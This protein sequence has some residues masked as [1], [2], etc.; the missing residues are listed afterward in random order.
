ML[1]FRVVVRL[2]VIESLCARV[3]NQVRSGLAMLGIAVAVAIV[4]LRTE[5]AGQSLGSAW[6]SAVISA[7][8]PP[9]LRR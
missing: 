8:W 1:P 4:A 9:L 2:L 5:Q 7:P 3:R 6:R